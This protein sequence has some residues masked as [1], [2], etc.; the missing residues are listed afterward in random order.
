[1]EKKQKYSRGTAVVYIFNLIVGVGALNLPLGFHQAGVI[2]G[3]IFL[4]F[5]AFLSYVINIM[6]NNDKRTLC[7]ILITNRGLINKNMQ[8]KYI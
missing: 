2:L 6:I 5:I 3:V 7:Y 4:G 8:I 1:M